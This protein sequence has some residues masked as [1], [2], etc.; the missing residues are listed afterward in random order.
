MPGRFYLPDPRIDRKALHQPSELLPA[1]IPQFTD[2]SGPAKP[3]GFQP[4]VEKKK[5]VTFPDQGFNP[6]RTP[7]AEK[8]DGPAAERIKIKPFFYDSGQPIDPI[9]EIRIAAGNVD[10]IKSGQIIQHARSPP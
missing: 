5:T 8:K 1:E 3:P 10:V 4:F 9:A 6:V 2:I 7:P